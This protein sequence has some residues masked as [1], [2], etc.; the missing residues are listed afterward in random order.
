MKK[1][2]KKG[3]RKVSFAKKGE[4]NTTRTPHSTTPGKRRRY[5]GAIGGF[6]TSQ[7]FLSPRL[8]LTRSNAGRLARSRL[9]EQTLPQSLRRRRSDDGPDLQPH[10]PKPPRRRR[11]S[12]PIPVR[13]LARAPRRCRGCRRP[14][15]ALWQPRPRLLRGAR[16]LFFDGCRRRGRSQERCRRL[17]RPGRHNAKRLRGHADDDSGPCARKQRKQQQWRKRCDDYLPVE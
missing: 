6:S 3:L 5:K 13:S 12:P 10:V 8:A 16:L 14:G 9:T 4:K 11:P 1:E 2:R 15:A 17:C 7:L